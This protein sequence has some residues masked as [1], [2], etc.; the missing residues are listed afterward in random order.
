MGSKTKFVLGEEMTSKVKFCWICSKKL[1]GNSSE[2]LMIDGYSRTLH[3]TCAKKVK[4]GYD[5]VKISD[6]Y[7]SVEW[8]LSG[9]FK[10]Y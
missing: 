7:H 1:W 8:T 3:K 2:V 10:E 4:R 9:S 5:F 6:G